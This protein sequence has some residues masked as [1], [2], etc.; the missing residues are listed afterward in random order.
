MTSVR[1]RLQPLSG[2]RWLIVLFIGLLLNACSPKTTIWESH[3]GENPAANKPVPPTR[4]VPPPVTPPPA[5][6]VSVISLLLP[7]GLDHIGPGQSYTDIS[8]KKAR[9]AADYYRGFDLALDSLTYYGYNYKLQLFD[10]RDDVGAAHSLAY[11]QKVR[12]SDLIVGPVFPDGM[13]A[14]ISVLTSAR[15]PIVSPL[16]PEPP[17]TFKNQNL[18]TVNPPLEYHA[19]C[20][21]QY[22]NDKLNPQKIFILRSGFSEDNDYIIPFKKA[23]DSLS[24]HRIKF[25]ELTVVHG[26]LQSIIPQLAPGKQNVFVVPSTDEAFLTITLQSLDKLT[27]KYPVTLF[28]H[29]SWQHFA[30]LKPQLLQHLKTHITSADNVNYKSKETITFIRNYRNAWHTE[31]TAY[32]IKGFDEGMY[33]GKLLGAANSLKNMDK[34]DFNGINSDFTF[35]KKV[36]MGWV[37]THVELLMYNN[38]ELI[39]AQ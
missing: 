2:N 18:V 6:K 33:F 23:I 19:W 13:K 7:F 29:P 21:A 35:Q 28:G 3:P 34:T 16:S 27:A 37:N 26:Q 39:K 1:N 30:F 24:N 31:P 25:V 14:F 36:G 17:T 10:T 5:P 9:I 11:D 38:F 4:S 15:K 12:A 22:I 8:L 20:A 32:A